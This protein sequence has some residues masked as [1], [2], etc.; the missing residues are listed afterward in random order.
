MW[1]NQDALV[2]AATRLLL[3]GA[4]P[5]HA[6]MP[7]LRRVISLGQALSLQPSLRSLHSIQWRAAVDADTRRG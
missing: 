5:S 4:V 7:I 2:R 6:L 3:Q 1:S